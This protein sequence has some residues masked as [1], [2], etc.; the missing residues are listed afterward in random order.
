NKLAE[1]Y[2]NRWTP[3]NPTSKWPSFVNPLSQGQRTVN[4]YTV[5]D[6]S[7]IRLKTVRLSYSLPPSILGGTFRKPSAYGMAANVFTIDDDIDSAP[8]ASPNTNA[9][10]RIDWNADPSVRTFSLGMSL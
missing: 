6:A 8:G 4:S 5:Q 9:N 10:F 2:L 7:Y 1:P 3:E